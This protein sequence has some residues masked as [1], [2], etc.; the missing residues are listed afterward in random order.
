MHRKSFIRPRQSIQRASTRRDHT[1]RGSLYGFVR[2]Y[3]S[4]SSVWLIINIIIGL[5]A[6]VKEKFFPGCSKKSCI[7]C[8]DGLQVDIP[9]PPSC[10]KGALDGGQEAKR[11][12][13]TTENLSP[14]PAGGGKGGACT[15]FCCT[16]K[17]N[18]N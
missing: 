9:L 6:F 3:S 5:P 8:G 14:T 2:V 17:S 13:K 4:A 10:A 15:I 11:Q 16:L 12:L 7:N 1:L 18:Y